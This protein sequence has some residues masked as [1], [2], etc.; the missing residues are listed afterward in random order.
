MKIKYLYTSVFLFLLLNAIVFV[1]FLDN[2]I[3]SNQSYPIKF[4]KESVDNKQL[5]MVN[6]NGN[7]I[8]LFSDSI[9]EKPLQGIKEADQQ[10][11]VTREYIN[12]DSGKKS[13]TDKDESEVIEIGEYIDPDAETE[14]QSD[15]ED[16]E[17][18]EIGEYIDPDAEIEPQSDK[19]E[20]E[21]IE[22]GEYMDPDAEIEPQSDKEESEVIEIGEYM[23][24]DL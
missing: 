1:L 14:P 24:V 16:S 9:I 2:K 4:K 22:I 10:Q 11:V 7:K 12:V 15:K 5:D 17:V 13:Q 20:S 21:V 19:E 18:T 3:F 8:H 23:D 6:K